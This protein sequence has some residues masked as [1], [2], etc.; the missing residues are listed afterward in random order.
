M[1]INAKFN[2]NTSAK[3]IRG[4]NVFEN[5]TATI[6]PTAVQV[7][8]YSS[9]GSTKDYTYSVYNGVSQYT[10]FKIVPNQTGCTFTSLTTGIS[11]VDAS[12]NVTWVS[13]GVSVTLVKNNKEALQV[14]QP[15][16]HVLPTASVQRI[17]N[18]VSTSLR[19][20]L[21]TQIAGW[22]SGKTYNA[23]NANH[24]IG[25][26]PNFQRNTNAPFPAWVFA[27]TS[28]GFYTPNLGTSAAGQ[29]D[30]M[31][32]ISPRHAVCAT[33]WA[34]SLVASKGV[35]G[36][37]TTLYWLDLNNV[38]WS[39]ECVDVSNLGS[40]LTVVYLRWISGAS[41]INPYY[42]LPTNF[43]SYIPSDVLTG[44]ALAVNLK[45]NDA[46][47]KVCTHRVL[48]ANGNGNYNYIVSSDP[49]YAPYA[50]WSSNISG[51]DSSG[52]VVYP[53]TVGGVNYPTLITCMFN[54]ASGPSYAQRITEINTAMNALARTYSDLTVYAANTVPT[55]V[56][57]TFSTY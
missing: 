54:P 2:T 12:G 23:T 39:A 51:G 42:V 9:A 18:F 55:A 33:H 8:A 49:F 1:T 38:L 48:N 44:D 24:Y 20:M 17:T 11:S 13:D 6:V 28:L 53:I 37:G 52:P 36:S 40:D 27:A 25:T 35:N 47:G 29:Q 41:S 31:H 45:A 43:A 4:L 3:K 16:Q 21:A 26:Y 57:N 15:I 5:I 14:L 50:V 56:M 34:G 32:L 46:S 30:P 19:Y 7:A 22:I 10:N